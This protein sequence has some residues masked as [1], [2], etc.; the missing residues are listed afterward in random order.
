MGK[1][2]RMPASAINYQHKFDLG[3][4]L[5]PGD[6]DWMKGVCE[7]NNC[8]ETNGAASEEGTASKVDM[9]QRAG[10]VFN[11]AFSHKMLYNKRL[12]KAGEILNRGCVYD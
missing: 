10:G 11:C 7:D 3:G 2:Q 8:S 5:S 1:N 6:V 12:P 4:C 9:I